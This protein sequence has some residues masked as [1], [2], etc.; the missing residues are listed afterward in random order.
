APADVPPA[1]VAVTVASSREPRSAAPRTY[2]ESLPATGAQFAPPASQRDHEYASVFPADGDHSPPPAASVPPTTAPP[3]RPPSR[4]AGRAAEAG[5]GEVPGRADGA[6]EPARTG[7][8]RAP[9]RH[10]LDRVAAGEAHRPQ[11][12]G[13]GPERVDEQ[14]RRPVGREDR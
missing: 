9:G 6:L 12:R 7:R 11:A 4:A 2:V 3:V 1:L 8:R 13:R 14:D 5:G 10:E